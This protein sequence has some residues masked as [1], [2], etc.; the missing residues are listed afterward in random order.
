M[1]SFIRISNNNLL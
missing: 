1:S